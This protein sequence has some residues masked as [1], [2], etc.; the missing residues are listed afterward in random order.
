MISHKTVIHLLQYSIILSIKW[1]YVKQ[2][3]S[4]DFDKIVAPQKRIVSNVIRITYANWTEYNWVCFCDEIKGVI[5]LHLTIIYFQ[6]F[7]KS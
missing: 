6:E 7:Q 2:S 3:K 4:D 5:S 1:V